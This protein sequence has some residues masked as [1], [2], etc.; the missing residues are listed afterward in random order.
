MKCDN[1]E[2]HKKMRGLNGAESDWISMDAVNND[3]KHNK[4]RG[5]N[6]AESDGISMHTVSMM[7]Y[8]RPK[9]AVFKASIIDEIKRRQ[10]RAEE[11]TPA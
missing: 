10:E 11:H 1:D 9:N 7:P 5:L 4:T 8:A 3:E 2:N 6:Y